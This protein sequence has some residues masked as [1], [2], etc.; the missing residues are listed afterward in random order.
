MKIK[1]KQKGK[2]KVKLSLL[3]LT[4]TDSLLDFGIMINIDF[5]K[6]ENQQLRLIYKFIILTILAIYLVLPTSALR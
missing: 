2:I 3:S 6:W 5:L 4:L 1:I